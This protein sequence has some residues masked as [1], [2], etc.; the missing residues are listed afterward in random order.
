MLELITDQSELENCQKQ[1]QQ[2]L[3][4]SLPN[5]GNYMI[6]H[7]G[8][9]FE[10][11]F[12]FNETLWYA[13]GVLTEAKNPR[14]WNSFGFNVNKEL[15]NGIIVEINIPINDENKNVSGLFAKN[16]RNGDTFIL[17]RGRVGGGR[18][19]IGKEA[20]LNWY[21]GA[22]VVVEANK[23]REEVLLVTGF[24]DRAF[25]EN[26]VY[27][28]TK[29][30]EF[31][32]LVSQG[33]YENYEN[34]VSQLNLSTYFPEF[35]GFKKSEHKNSYTAECNHGR[36]IDALKKHLENL[37]ESEDLE[38]Y[39]NRY[40]DL[41]MIKKKKIIKIYEV[42]TYLNKQTIY[43]AIGQLIYHGI[44]NKVQSLVLVL[45]KMS[46]ELRKFLSNFRS[47]NIEFLEYELR[48]KKVRFIHPNKNLV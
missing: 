42:K 5:T 26:L 46:D 30:E 47:I 2:L 39:N 40:I 4:K 21:P 17:H 10:N 44:H 25:R 14:Y 45:P 41:A 8:G 32:K 22:R 36:I 15:P 7:L 35:R 20:F 23:Y 28:I 34:R 13:P 3:R 33:K 37:K 9:S 16:Q 43:T 18:K 27:F 31:K 48:D 6:G 11:E 38:F 12:W 19:G 29:V 1:F 24:A